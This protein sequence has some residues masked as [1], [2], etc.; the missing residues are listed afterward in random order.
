[1]RPP[2]PKRCSRDAKVQR[3]AGLPSKPARSRG[4]CQAELRVSPAPFCGSSEAVDLDPP[5]HPD[6]SSRPTARLS[7][8]P[9]SGALLA[10]GPA[11]WRLLGPNG[12][13]KAA[14][15]DRTGAAPANQPVSAPQPANPD[16]EE[17]L[18]RAARGASRDA[19]EVS[20]ELLGDYLPMP[21]A[22]ATFGRRPTRKRLAAVHQLGRPGP[23]RDFRPAGGRPLPVPRSDACGVNCPRSCAHATAPPIGQRPTRCCMSSTMLS[24][25]SQKGRP[26]RAG[27]G[28]P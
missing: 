22:A 21:A 14:A 2:T 1:M 10:R 23:V 28:P 26:R 6:R 17:W 4:C 20:E 7:G 15:M 16:R 19:G 9:T 13:T 24:H 3:L 27:A 11:N 5:S 8:R 18:T 12:P 25:P